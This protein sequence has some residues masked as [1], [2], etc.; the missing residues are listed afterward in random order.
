MDRLLA[1]KIVVISGGT[2]GVGRRLV[3]ACTQHGAR[4]VFGG[5][6]RMA[7]EKIT[8]AAKTAGG[9][10]RFVYT[11][12][13]ST[14]HC[15][16]L[17]DAALE[18]HG[19]VDGFVNYAGITPAAALTDCE[20]ALFDSI[21]DVNIKAAFFCAKYAV[22]AMKQHGGGSIVMFG[23]AHSWTGQKDRAAYAVSKG[24]LFTLSEHIAHH[25]AEDHI[26]CNFL[27]MGWTPT[28]GELMLRRSQGISETQLLE[29]A[30][31]ILPMGRMCTAEDHVPGV[32]YL[33]SD[34]SAMVTGANLRITGG[35]Y[36]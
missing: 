24:A 10:A 7:A 30:T 26:R 31:E 4:V 14:V 18:A 17:F 22:C 11:D 15:K 1:G 3:H 8:E 12:L 25:Y 23:S 33:L 27:T 19:R 35:E 9:D 29:M 16:R 32:L 36:I 6:D 2:K 5:R 21:F 28:D 20:E 13:L 34:Y